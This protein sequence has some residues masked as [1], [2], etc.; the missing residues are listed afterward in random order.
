[1]IGLVARTGPNR[2]KRS[3][4]ARGYLEAN[5]HRP[6][7]KVLCEALSTNIV[8]EGNVAKGVAFMHSGTKHTV[9]VKKEVIV[10]CGVIQSP[11]LL[12]LSGIGDPEV[13]KA[14]GVECKVEN[15]GVGNN[16]QDHSLTI[17]CYE[18]APGVMSL[19]A[20]YDPT[21]MADAQKTLMEKAGGPL[22]GISSC[23]GF[24]PYKLF[25]SDEELKETVQSI[26][27]TK[28]RTPYE[29]KQLEQIIAH[30]ESD[31]S[32]NLQMVA[33]CA[34][35]GYEHGIQDQSKL[36]PPVD[37]SKGM[38]ATLVICLQVR[39]LGLGDASHAPNLRFAC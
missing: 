31:T 37:P 16:F 36:F 26:K 2:G 18:L 11:Q 4:A 1:L 5:K 6:N 34:T 24:F 17:G 8:L 25:T 9:N 13:L 19:D 38:G 39:S 22:T 14:A 20:I 29:K 12:E 32:A 3:Y 30:L 23:Q 33:V 28:F 27:D 7:L 10:S 15:L 35:G 21:V